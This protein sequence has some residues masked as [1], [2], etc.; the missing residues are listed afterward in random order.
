MILMSRGLPTG[1]L[2]ADLFLLLGRAGPSIEWVRLP[3][4]TR[5]I[6]LRAL[7]GTCGRDRDCRGQSERS[8]KQ[9]ETDE[10]VKVGRR[11]AH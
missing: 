3:Q 2:P 8:R 7:T 11:A 1:L 5:W 9:A 10:T 6:G 4:Q